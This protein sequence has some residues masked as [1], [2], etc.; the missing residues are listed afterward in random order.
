MPRGNGRGPM[1]SGPMTGRGAGFCGGYGAPGYMNF[2]GMGVRCGRSGFGGGGH[3]WRNR[4]YETG[5]TGWMRSEQYGGTCVNTDQE[6]VKQTL[7]ARVEA[8]QAEL[9]IMRKRLDSLDE[10]AGEAL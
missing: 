2:G 4:Y 9:D 3:G 10:S 5:L 7:K 1:G 8:L 6:Q